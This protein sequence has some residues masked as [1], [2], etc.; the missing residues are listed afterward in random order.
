MLLPLRSQRS[1]TPQAARRGAQVAGRRDGR[2]R[3]LGKAE[4]EAAT[5]EA[6]AGIAAEIPTTAAADAATTGAPPKRR[7]QIPIL[8]RAAPRQCSR[9]KVHDSQMLLPLRVTDEQG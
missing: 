9:G 1:E 8:S 3:A 4:G 7:S 5:G 6:E 2:A